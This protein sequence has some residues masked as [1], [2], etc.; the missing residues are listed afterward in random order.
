M[1]KKV[2][3]GSWRKKE[4]QLGMGK[5]ELRGGEGKVEPACR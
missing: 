4:G 1:R 3:V 5:E 2:G